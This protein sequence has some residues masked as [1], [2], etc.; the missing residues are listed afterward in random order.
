MDADAPK[1][2][3]RRWAWGAI[4]L[5]SVLLAGLWLLTAPCARSSWS[6]PCF[7]LAVYAL[8]YLP[9]RA[10]LALLG[11]EL[12][13]LE[14]FSLSLLVGIN[15]T[16]A[17]YFLLGL[18]R[19]TRLIVAWPIL[20]GA[21]VL[22]WRRASARRFEP[23]ADSSHVA[24][25]GIMALAVLPLAVLP[26]YFPNACP[27]P[28][29]GLS[30]YRLAD[31]ELHLSVANELTHQIPPQVPFLPGT[32]LRYHYGMDL[33][34]A[35][36]ASIGPLSVPDLTVRFLPVLF[37]VST[38]LAV[39]CVS[40]AWLGSSRGALLTTLLVVLGED[41]SFVPGLLLRSPQPWAVSFF[42]MPNV[43]S[44]YLLNPIL[45]AVGL[46]FGALFCLLSFW[47]TNDRRWLL[48]TS[49]TVAAL[50][51][52]K[53]FA[54]AQ[55]LLCLGLAGA[56]CFLR[57][58]DGRLLKATAAA[59]TL[60]VPLALWLSGWPNP[61]VVAELRPW[62]YVPAMLAAI[63][64]GD[65]PFAQRIAALFMGGPVTLAGVCG[66]VLVALPAYLLGTWGLRVL[67]IPR[68]L[69]GCFRPTLDSGFRSL[70]ALFVIVGT[71]IALTCAL[72][73]AGFPAFSRYN[74][75]AW[76]LVQSKYVAWVFVVEALMAWSRG[77][78]RLLRNALAMAAV[79][80]ALPSSIQ[81]FVYQ[82]SQSSTSRIDAPESGVLRFLD[83]SARP[84]DV[85]FAPPPVAEH[86][87]SL[88][89]CRAPVLTIY[90]WSFISL[91]DLERRR[92]DQA[93]FWTAWAQGQVRTDVLE[94]LQAAFLVTGRPP[95][96]M[97]P[98]ASTGLTVAF[99]NQGFVVYRIARE[100]PPAP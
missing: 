98:A 42:F 61:R 9:G 10:C 76:F 96:G 100:K 53:L 72:T 78:S 18:A 68:A 14:A 15:L 19:V 48:P 16:G 24:L 38:V 45:P 28:D 12:S 95:S 49:L 79:G 4:G 2:T 87:V 30:F 27:S 8:G 56:V 62:P 67:G 52:Y 57:W 93:A 59:L 1:D 91:A 6:F 64:T 82:A 73:P 33:L 51:E 60:A 90:P 17:V 21:L 50:V 13:A 81:Y 54:A 47:R 32:P 74:E 99:E 97:P 89:R 84:G 88:T 26:L 39:F 71:P 58:R 63:G 22:I 34:A 86:V 85:V 43:V 29:G 65:T 55:L 20:A 80:L 77:R 46:L 5:A 25:V 36:F 75:T 69:A 3:S 44:P 11:V 23:S 40:R 92:Q 94:T 66:F 31:L 41:F 7:A 35:A 37:Q 83:Q 70:L